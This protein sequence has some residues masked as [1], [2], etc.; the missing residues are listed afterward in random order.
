VFS[1][2]ASSVGDPKVRK[3]KQVQTQKKKK[4]KK[5]ETS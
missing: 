3:F 1:L 4:K 5:K 2:H